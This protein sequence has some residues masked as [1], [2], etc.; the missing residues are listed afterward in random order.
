[1]RHGQPPILGESGILVQYLVC[2]RVVNPLFTNR[3]L[4]NMKHADKPFLI[5][6]VLAMSVL[7]ACLALLS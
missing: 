7:Y 1:M 5:G 2:T 6:I 4:P 3:F